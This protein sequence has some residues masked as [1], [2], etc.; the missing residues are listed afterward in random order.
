[1]ARNKF[2][3]G[4]YGEPLHNEAIGAMSY[5]ILPGPRYD[6]MDGVYVLADK[7]ADIEKITA[8]QKQLAQHPSD[9]ETSTV[10]VVYLTKSGKKTVRWYSVKSKKVEDALLSL[11]DTE[12]FK[13]TYSDLLL[14]TD[15]SR[16]AEKSKQLGYT[17]YQLYGYLSGDIGDLED[18]KQLFAESEATFMPFYADTVND[19]SGVPVENTKALRE[20]LVQDM[21]EATYL[22]RYRAQETELGVLSFSAPPEQVDDS[23]EYIGDI[24]DAPFG[25]YEYRVYPSMKNTVAY[26]TKAG[27]IT[28]KETLFPVQPESAYVVKISDFTE[29][30]GWTV[31]GMENA[32]LFSAFTAGVDALD[33]EVAYFKGDELMSPLKNLKDYFGNNEITDKAQLQQLMGASRAYALAKDDDYMVCYRYRDSFGT[34]WYQFMLIYGSE[35]PIG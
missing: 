3:G 30:R 16:L 11:T 24:M 12:A 4:G 8:L 19:I 34:E 35:Y 28:G 9:R 31:T 27:V 14:G 32:I 5:D 1:M 21:N 17:M 18:F 10:C 25:T 29:N 26:L 15:N 2:T 7:K 33:N 13:E 6:A 23:G 22:D 20:A